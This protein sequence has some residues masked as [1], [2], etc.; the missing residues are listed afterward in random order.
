MSLRKNKLAEPVR[1]DIKKNDTVKVISG[2]DKGK[3]GRVLSVDK[4]RGRL[5]VE[6]VMAEWL[7]LA[8]AVPIGLGDAD[9]GPWRRFQVGD[10]IGEKFQFR[11]VSQYIGPDVVP[12]VGSVLSN[13]RH[14]CAPVS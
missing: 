14:W 7:P 5:L 13:A 2:R 12:D 9:F 11:L 10:Y 6:H 4:T 1:I 3:T 8:S